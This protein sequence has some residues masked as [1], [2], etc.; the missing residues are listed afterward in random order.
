MKR[1]ARYF[2]QQFDSPAGPWKLHLSQPAYELEDAVEILWA[3]E[4]QTRSFSEH[5]LPRRVVD[6]IFNLGQ[7][8]WLLG[9]RGDSLHRRAWLSGLQQTPFHVRSPEPPVLIGARIR[10]VFLRRL[11]GA[12][13]LDLA[14]RVVD[15]DDLHGLAQEPCRQKMLAAPDWE[16]RFTHLEDWLVARWR[17]GPAAD[18]GLVWTA[19]LLEAGVRRVADLRRELGWSHRLLIERFR[20]EVGF[21]P[22]QYGRLARFTRMV[23]LAGDADG[24]NWA[25]LALR[26]GYYDQA[27]SIH[28][29]QI[30]ARVAPGEFL[31]LRDESNQAIAIREAG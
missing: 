2:T 12:T 20:R 3:V 7:P 13:G 30:F 1:A 17:K 29:F 19:G 16:T 28:E 9:A 25:D 14:G 18:A 15:L 8:H 4:A 22:K 10:P 31:R 24:A 21:A 5:V 23:E 26:A 6:V 11:F 27:H